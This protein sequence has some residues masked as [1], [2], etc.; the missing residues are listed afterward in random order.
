MIS[1]LAVALALP[2]GAA[3]QAIPRTSGSSS[4]GSSSGSSAPPTTSS[5]SGSS[6]SQQPV[7]SAPPSS[8]RTGSV[9]SGESSSAS[10][11]S[12]AG[13]G[14]AIRRGGDGAAGGRAVGGRAIGGDDRSVY[15]GAGSRDRDGRPTYG[16]AIRRTS[17]IVGGGYFDDKWLHYAGYP[18]SPWGRW[19]PWYAGGWGYGWVS[20][21]PWRFGGT[22]WV[23]GRYGTWWYGAT[24]WYDP[25]YDPY[26]D[27][28]GYY[29]MYMG[30]GGGGYHESS[31]MGSLRVKVS[32]SDAQ[33]YV[34][35]V[36][37][38]VVDDFDGLRNHLEVPMGDHKIE[39]KKDGYE[40]LTGDVTVEADKTLTFRG[41]LK[42]KS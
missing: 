21:D 14:I 36:L 23:W 41:S 3:A 37:Q 11:S 39:I 22:R 35:G 17:P 24:P 5:S 19:Y 16:T 40:T 42:K 34:D 10:G 13:G 12:R 8:G 26:F 9:G 29:G 27:P 20:Y 4:S 6:G 7:R 28:Y 30:G 31:M 18:F 2:A 1:G 38:G 32:P 15:V 25:W 33:V